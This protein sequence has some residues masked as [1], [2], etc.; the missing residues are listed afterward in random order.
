MIWKCAKKLIPHLTIA[1]KSSR[2][3]MFTLLRIQ[4]TLTADIAVTAQEEQWCQ[5]SKG[6]LIIITRYRSM[7]FLKLS[8]MEERMLYLQISGILFQ[9]VRIIL[10]FHSII[11]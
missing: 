2:F 10:N 5:V 8:H 4:D 6:K 7:V 3:I 1:E 9:L 11:L